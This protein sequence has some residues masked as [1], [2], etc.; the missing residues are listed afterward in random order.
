M[1]RLSLWSVL[2]L[3]FV[4]LSV[5]KAQEQPAEPA[6]TTPP[7]LTSAVL[8]S[9]VETPAA[10]TNELTPELLNKLQLA[11]QHVKAN[12]PSEALAVY[13]EFLGARSDMFGPY[14]DRGKLYHSQKEYA[15]AIDDY[16]AALK[17]KEDLM[18]AYLR[19]CMAQYES[20]AYAK[21]IPDCDKYI[22]S[23]PKNI[24]YEPYYYKGMA[25]AGL[26]EYDKTIS[27]LAKAF[28]ISNDL[29]DGHMLLGR[30]YT[31]QDHLLHALREY[32]VVLQQRPGDK[33]ALKHRGTIKAA[34]GDELGSKEDL[35]KAR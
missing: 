32:T 29:P 30:I 22:D 20:G 19:R 27:M 23:K 16:T 2:T 4:N 5:G 12:Q 21:A 10:A 18:D 13:T 34:L 17:I 6:K 26:R 7:V 31:E 14:I 8:T 25:H 3:L 15:K 9:A 1:K 24:T 33:V 11:A 35:A 28:E